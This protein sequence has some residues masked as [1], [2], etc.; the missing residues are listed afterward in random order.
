MSQQH[1]TQCLHYPLVRDHPKGC[2]LIVMFLVEH[3]FLML[4]L[5]MSSLTELLKLMQMLQVAYMLHLIL[6][7]TY[8]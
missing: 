7:L 2:T 1:Q 5:G 8:N 4:A 3:Q 6:N